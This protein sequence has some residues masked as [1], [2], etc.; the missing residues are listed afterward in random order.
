MLRQTQHGV[1]AKQLAG[2]LFFLCRR[3]SVSIH[4]SAGAAKL[5]NRR[6]FRNRRR[7]S[8]EEY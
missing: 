6:S 1:E 4:F 5:L 3:R 7:V 8:V 2:L